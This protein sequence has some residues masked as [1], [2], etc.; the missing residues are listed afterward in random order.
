MSSPSQPPEDSSQLPPT[1]EQP[2]E[3]EPGHPGSLQWDGTQRQWVPPSL[4]HAWGPGSQ[5]WLTMSNPA[6]QIAQGSGVPQTPYPPA[7][8]SQQP[9]A[10]GGEAGQQQGATPSSSRQIPL[11]P[12]HQSN[13]GRHPGQPLW[14]SGGSSGQTISS[15][16]PGFAHSQ[17]TA[18]PPPP[19]LFLRFSSQKRDV[20]NADVVDNH[21]RVLYRVESD[22]KSTGIFD[23]NNRV[24]A[25]IDW[26]HSNP[27]LT[28]YERKMKVNEW[29]PMAEAS[30]GRV[31]SHNGRPY[32]WRE[33]NGLFV[34]KSSAGRNMAR[35][36][37]NG[38]VEIEILPEGLQLGLLESVL[39]S[40]ILMASGR[41]LGD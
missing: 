40:V 13:P 20:L 11:P 39:L 3:G 30:N 16:S 29:I 38:Y 35:C 37:A 7:T 10:P 4:P 21:G 32:T 31:I 27:R 6:G 8:A 15:G 2:V 5:Q 34:L 22:R 14:S 23:H 26:H 18:A 1:F 33:A 12:I 36:N 41:P 17:G 19:S 25:V 24:L 9:W 28:Y